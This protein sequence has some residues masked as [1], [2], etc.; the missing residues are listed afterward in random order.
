MG[1]RK[2]KHCF[3]NGHGF[4]RSQHRH[5]L[6]NIESQIEK[7]N[8]LGRHI[9]LLHSDPYQPAVQLHSSGAMQV[10]WMHVSHMAR[11]C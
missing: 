3:R 1:N 7:E 6:R 9:L 11:R 5:M 10:P 4:G 2:H 8:N